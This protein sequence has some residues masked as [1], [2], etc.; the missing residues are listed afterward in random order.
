MWFFWAQN[1]TCMH[2][3]N[4]IKSGKKPSPY[5]IKYTFTFFIFSF[6]EKIET[7]T[8][9]K[10]RCKSNATFVYYSMKL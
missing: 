2:V 6:E 3:W 10:M 7:Q 9:K 5:I 1:I 8:K 4:T